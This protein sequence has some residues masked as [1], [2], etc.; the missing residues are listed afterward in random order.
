[1][2]RTSILNTPRTVSVGATATLV[3]DATEPWA[4]RRFRNAAASASVF[5]GNA[6]VTAS[7]TNKG[8]ELKAGEILE[9]DYTN[10]QIWM[11]TA[12]GTADVSVIEVG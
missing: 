9:I 6:S 8:Q 7:S 5:W 2:P 12:S 3:S 10:S 1:M 4:F 11:I